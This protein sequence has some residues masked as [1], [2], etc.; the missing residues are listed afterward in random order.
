VIVYL[1]KYSVP[2]NSHTF[3]H[4]KHLQSRGVWRNPRF[5]HSPPVADLNAW[6][7]R[8]NVFTK[9]W[10]ILVKLEAGV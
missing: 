5:R 8:V 7:P 6:T 1:T 9:S 4:V 2:K 3:D 10:P